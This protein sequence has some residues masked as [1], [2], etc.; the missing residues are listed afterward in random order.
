MVTEVFQDIEVSQCIPVSNISKRPTHSRHR[1]ITRLFCKQLTFAYPKS[2]EL[3]FSEIDFKIGGLNCIVGRSGSG[4][5]SFTNLLT[6]LFE[7]NSGEICYFS[8]DKPVPK[9]E[10]SFSYCSQQPVIFDA[11]VEENLISVP[12]DFQNILKIIDISFVSKGYQIHSKNLSGGE[13]QRIGIARAL[14]VKSDIYIFDEPTAALDDH[15]VQKFIKGITNF[16]KENL[17]IIVTHDDRLIL[18]AD[19]LLSLN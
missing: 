17:V 1:Q 3:K 14:N 15:N 4:K 12:A 18:K 8:G 19:R 6:D 5:S 2:P 11:T 13:R 16:S 9:N 7:P 10:I